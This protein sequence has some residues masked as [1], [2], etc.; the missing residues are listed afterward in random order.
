M[1]TPYEYGFRL[2]NGTQIVHGDGGLTRSA[3]PPEANIPGDLTMLSPG[4]RADSGTPCFCGPQGLLP[5]TTENRM[6]RHVHMATDSTTNGKRYIVEKI[7]VMDGIGIA[8]L[9]GELYVVPPKTCVLIGPGVPHAWVACPPG[10]DLQAIGVANEK[11]V[12]DGK[13]IAVFE[14][15]EP[16]AFYPTAQTETLKTEKDYV[17]CDDLQSIRIPVLTLD[18]IRKQAK[19]IWGRKV[20]KLSEFFQ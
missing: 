20:C 5:F 8:E 3:F 2:A 17:R 4:H 12:S 18:D 16:T 6:P 9:G 13:F 10:L 19:F 11:V 14:Y 15:E 7:V 1:T